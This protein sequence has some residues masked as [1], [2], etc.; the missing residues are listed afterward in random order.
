MIHLKSKLAQLVA[1]SVALFSEDADKTPGCSVCV[2]EF[3]PC[4]QQTAIGLSARVSLIVGV[5]ELEPCLSI[6]SQSLI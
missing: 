4:S 2:G 3:G 1:T 6:E 5:R